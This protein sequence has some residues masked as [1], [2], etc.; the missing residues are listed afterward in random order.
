MS[1]RKPFW[2]CLR[3]G[4]SL[5]G[6]RVLDISDMRPSGGPEGMTEDR[7]EQFCSWTCI[8]GLALLRMEDER[9]QEEARR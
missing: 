6:E 5:D 1:A 2:V 4:K 7:A 8:Y 9:R 3:C